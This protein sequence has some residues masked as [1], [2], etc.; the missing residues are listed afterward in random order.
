MSNGG[1]DKCDGIFVVCPHIT[2][3]PFLA[4]SQSAAHRFPQWS[5]TPLGLGT[6]RHG[7]KA[8]ANVNSV[9][10]T[11]VE[12]VGRDEDVGPQGSLNAVIAEMLQRNGTATA[13]SPSALGRAKPQA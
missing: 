3:L 10:W 8:E 11:L 7:A 1:S 2:E 9:D 6:G 12:A 13:R 5:I 4:F